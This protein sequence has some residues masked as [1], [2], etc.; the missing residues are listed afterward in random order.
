MYFSPNNTSPT[1]P[2]LST[3]AT[4]LPTKGLQIDSSSNSERQTSQ[5]WPKKRPEHEK[6]QQPNTPNGKVAS[7]QPKPKRRSKAIVEHCGAFEVADQV[8]E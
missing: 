8:I 2:K 6:H 7:E 5:Q 3:I 4:K 1:A